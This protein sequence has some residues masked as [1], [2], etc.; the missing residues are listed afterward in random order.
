MIGSAAF[1]FGLTH[2]SAADGVSRSAESIHQEVVIKA[3]AKRI[4]DALTEARQ[5]DKVVELSGAIREMSLATKA[6]EISREVGGSFTIFG[7]YITGRQLEL[8]PNER[9]VEAWRVGSWKP[10]V[11]SIVRF[12]FVEMAGATR[13]V[14]DHTGFPAGTGEQLA[15]GWKAHYWEPLKKLLA[16]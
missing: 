1:L 14:F 10:G 2:L 12:E 4:Y 3:T 11:Y 6:S 8:V 16:P 7:G 9:I 15:E 13:I 5:F